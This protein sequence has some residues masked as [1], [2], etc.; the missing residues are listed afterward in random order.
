MKNKIILLTFFMSLL[1]ISISGSLFYQGPT[2]IKTQRLF[3]DIFHTEEGAQLA[4]NAKFTLVNTGD[5]SNHV[6]YSYNLFE[7]EKKGELTLQPGEEKKISS[8]FNKVIQGPYFS[9]SIEFYLSL[10]GSLVQED[11]ERGEFLIDLPKEFT[12]LSLSEGPDQKD[13]GTYKWITEEDGQGFSLEMSWTKADINIDL[14][15]KVEPDQVKLGDKIDFTYKIENRDSKSYQA[16]IKDLYRSKDLTPINRSRFEKIEPEQEY[17]YWVYETNLTLEEEETKEIELA[18]EVNNNSYT[19]HMS[20]KGFLFSI[21]EVGY[22]KRANRSSY[23]VIKCD[24]DRVCE[25]EEGENY[26][27]CKADC[28]SGSKDNY[29]DGVE[30]GTCDPDCKSY[31]DVDCGEEVVSDGDDETKTILTSPLVL[32]GLGIVIIIILILALSIERK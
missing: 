6:E 16:S 30:D 27:I 24:E 28:S 14:D 9:Q 11:I 12:L 2:E 4:A 31:Q 20:P 19:G 32:A 10:N 26:N 29:C 22:M 3:I 1:V 18:F 23:T 15:K 5:T 13:Q 8:S 21:P 7:E 17:N 25:V